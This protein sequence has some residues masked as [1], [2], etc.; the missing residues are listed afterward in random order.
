MK[1][2]QGNMSVAEYDSKFGKLMIY[3]LLYVGVE[4]KRLKCV[5]FELGLRPCYKEKGEHPRN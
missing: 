3:Y 1:L 2:E 4:T 5:K